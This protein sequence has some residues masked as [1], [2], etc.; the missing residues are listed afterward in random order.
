MNNQFKQTIEL[1]DSSNFYYIVAIN[2]QSVYSFINKHYADTFF[3]IHGD[4]VGK[5]YQITMHADDTKICQEVAAKCFQQPD[6]L[7][8]ATIRKHDGKGGYVI[9]QWEYKAMLNDDGSPDG[10]FCIGYDI[11]KFVEESNQL[12]LSQKDL[13]ETQSLLEKK[14][15]ILQQIIFH[16]SHIIRH[17]LTNILALV[18]ILQKLEVD[19]NL[20]SILDM[21]IESSNQLD[22]VIREIV[23]K[24]YE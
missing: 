15:K 18:N 6:K 11:T 24:T 13:E 22:N 17:P 8:P 10:I 23:N 4:M 14:E 1:L 16:Q 12:S 19:Q 3:H 7:F 20:K 9:T 21:L 2:M 5:P